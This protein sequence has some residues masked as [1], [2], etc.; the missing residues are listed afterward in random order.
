M[1]D[2]LICAAQYPAADCADPLTGASVVEAC[3]VLCGKCLPLL[4]N[5]VPDAA[6]CP[7]KY[8]S[9]DCANAIVGDSVRGACPAL[10]KV[11]P[12]A[13]TTA[14][15]ADAVD[16]AD[17]TAGTDAVDVSAAAVE[18][19]TTAAPEATAGA[20]RPIGA[21]A[22]GDGGGDGGAG[23]GAWVYVV[24]TLAI[25]GCVACAVA[26]IRWFQGRQAGQAD[27]FAMSFANATYV[28]AS[29]ANDDGELYG[30]NADQATYAEFPESLRPARGFSM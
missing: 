2:P 17:T 19:K 20:G 24:I 29:P 4:C 22:T 16:A 27:G 10:C 25:V 11:C 7:A 5:G 18:T 8:G 30:T 14:A 3:P 26:A 1:G 12:D 23:A 21:V 6:L 15:T 13:K 28:G 9:E